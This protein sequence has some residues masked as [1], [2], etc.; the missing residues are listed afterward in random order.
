ITP[1]ELAFKGEEKT[2]WEKAW[3]SAPQKIKD[4]WKKSGKY[5]EFLELDAQLKDEATL[6]SEQAKEDMI[7][8]WGDM[9]GDLRED[10]KKATATQEETKGEKKPPVGNVFKKK[11]KVNE[12]GVVTNPTIVR[13]PLDPKLKFEVEVSLAETPE[14]K[15]AVGSSISKQMG[16]HGGTVSGV[17]VHTDKL[18]YTKDEAIAAVMKKAIAFAKKEDSI[19]EKAWSKLQPKIIEELEGI[20]EVSTMERSITKARKKEIME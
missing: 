10:I 3:D 7:E 2:D 19:S 14:G 15:W 8:E 1:K 11:Y 16:D 5:D 6:E 4:E 9:V 12:H 17:S 13:M 20:L 18:F